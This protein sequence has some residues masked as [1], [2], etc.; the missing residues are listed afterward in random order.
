MTRYRQYPP[1]FMFIIACIAAAVILI[2]SGCATTGQQPTLE[3]VKAQAC[4]VILGT[5]AGL[6]VSPDIPDATKAR[7]SEIEPV[8]L[9]VCSTATEIGDIKQMS[10]AVF[11]V[12]VDVVKDSNMTPEQKQASII[13][14][15]TAR[16]MI[17]TYKVPQ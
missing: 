17:A 14:I 5:L 15:T 11:A 8:A 9:S 1:V 12:V 7:L 16:L 2:L 6:Q 3:D 4:P 13:A 10:E